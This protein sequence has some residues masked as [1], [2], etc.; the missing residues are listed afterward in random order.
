[1][2]LCWSILP[3]WVE[4]RHNLFSGWLRQQRWMWAPDQFQPTLNIWPLKKLNI[5]GASGAQTRYDV[6]WNFAPIIFLA[7][8]SSFVS[9]WLHLKGGR[10]VCRSVVEETTSKGILSKT[11]HINVE[12]KKMVLCIFSIL[13]NNWSNRRSTIILPE[14]IY[15]NR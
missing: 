8:C 12:N 7:H 9:R 1:M 2:Y 3:F 6:L 10:G 5:W 13:L 14:Y 11:P 4:Q 15:M